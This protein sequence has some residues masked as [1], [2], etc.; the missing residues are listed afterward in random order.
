MTFKLEMLCWCG[1]LAVF[2]HQTWR[3]RAK[4]HPLAEVSMKCQSVSSCL[5][6]AVKCGMKSRLSCN[7]GFY[8]VSFSQ[9]FRFLMLRIEKNLQIH[10]FVSTNLYRIGNSYSKTSFLHSRFMQ[11]FFHD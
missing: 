11:Y 7:Y 8:L 6:L 9:S 1:A 3:C 10:S 2:F 5:L 4:T